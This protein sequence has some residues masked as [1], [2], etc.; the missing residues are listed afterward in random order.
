MFMP[1]TSWRPDVNGLNA[2]TVRDVR[3]VM[4]AP[5]GFRPV[6]AHVAV[7]PALPGRAIGAATVRSPEGAAATMAGTDQR[8]Y[9]LQS[10]AW[11]DATRLSG[12]YGT[13]VPDRWRFEQFGNI[14]IA[15]NGTDDPQKLDLGTPDRFSALGGSPPKAKFI[16]VIGDFVVL[17]NLVSG[18]GNRI[19]WCGLGNAE[20]W[21]PGQQNS[22]FQDFYAGGAITGLAGG[23]VGYVF[24]REKIRRMIFTPGSRFVFQIDEVER[25]RGCV[26]SSS[27]VQV[28]ARIYFLAN[29]GFYGLDQAS[30]RSEPIDEFK[31]REFFRGDVRAA[32]ESSIVGAVDPQTRL[33]YWSYIS[34]D[35]SSDVPDRVLIY[36]WALKEWTKA[37]LGIQAFVPFVGQSYTLDTMDSFGPL[38]TLP[39][40]LD[41]EFWLGGQGAVG[42][43][44]Q[45]GELGSLSGTPLAAMI[46]TNTTKIEG[47]AN[48]Y[49]SA[50]VPE[51][52]TRAATVMV[53]GAQGHGDPIVYDL[54]SG[55][56][57]TGETHQH[58]AARYMRGRLEVPAGTDWTLAQGLDVTAGADGER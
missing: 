37:D 34:R 39:Y 35:N 42:I 24:Q 23:E 6:R 7:V 47:N 46:E 31:C 54:P 49:V 19:Q 5:N 36:N 26:A 10:G 57:E 29:D 12:V 8:L 20:F 40:P 25:E 21:T 16:G 27:I 33:I 50:V 30:G 17:G 22:D 2:K 13:V 52:D 41:S 9:R 28:G 38:D 48:T 55:I 15:V 18:F 4:P 45:D 11:I 1:F 32:T 44:D 53:G 56:E 51:I 43:I 14:A 3:N 58:V